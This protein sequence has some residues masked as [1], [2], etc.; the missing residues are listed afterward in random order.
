MPIYTFITEKAGS[1]IIEQFSA[2]T[3]RAARSRWHAASKAE[4]GPLPDQLED[5]APRPITGTTGVWCFDGLDPQ[6][7][8]YLVHVVETR[9]GTKRERQ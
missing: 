6:N 4:P 8:F 3:L 5:M 7:T 2:R 1:T 9:P